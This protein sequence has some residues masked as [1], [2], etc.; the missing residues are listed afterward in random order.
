[1]TAEKG[2]KKRRIFSMSRKIIGLVFCFLLVVSSLM[3]VFAAQPAI[4]NELVLITPVSKFIVDA[5]LE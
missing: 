4:E 5:A 3:T 1:M 2:I